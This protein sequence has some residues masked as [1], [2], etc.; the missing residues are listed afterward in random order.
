MF[1]DNVL[2]ASKMGNQ[3]YLNGILN[4]NIPDAIDPGHP[5]FLATLMALGWKIFGKT[6]AVSHWLMLPF[7]FG[8]LW[9]LHSFV[10]FFVKDKKLQIWG[11]LLVIADPTLLSQLVLVNP[12]VIQLFFFFTAINALLRNNIYLK[13]IALSFLG[14][15][16]Y[17]GMML[18]AGVFFIE[19]VLHVFVN[20]KDAKSFFT[21]R[22]I[23]GYLIS[24]IPAIIYIV[25]RLHTKGWISSNPLEIWGNSWGFS[26]LSDFIRNFFW[27]VLVLGQRFIDFGRVFLLSFALTMLYRKRKSNELEKIKPLIV[28]FFFS[29][30]VIYTVSL[31][32]INPLGH[33]YFI[34]SYVTLGLI[35]FILLQ[36]FK[37]RKWLYSGFIISL[38]LGNFIV[39][40]DDFAQGWDVSLAHLPYWG[41]RKNAI[42]YMDDNQIAIEETASF[43]PN[44][45]TI[46]NIDV[47]GDMRSFLNFSGKEEYV[48]YSNVY[49][50]SD[51]EFKLLY[52]KYKQ[53][54]SFEKQNVR[55]ELLKRNRY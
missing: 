40:S 14:I 5:P 30:I 45:T 29:T 28:I 47:N 38:L 46:D 25:W 34:P 27:N 3:L 11:T 49:N 24:A 51:S 33:R 50:L 37:I 17:R 12:E 42:E 2:F 16:T 22:M 19:I 18:C 20:K 36:Q 4:W 44:C 26:S 53:L 9:Q 39:Y 43:F 41:L 55:V 52:Q 21:K 48:L 15:I 13:V 31:L 10:A 8:L 6:L 32:I 7:I 54:K 1:W 23:T 35:T